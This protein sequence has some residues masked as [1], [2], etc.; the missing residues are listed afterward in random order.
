MGNKENAL[1]A[2]N[3]ILK[4]GSYEVLEKALGKF[5]PELFEIAPQYPNEIYY[6]YT[7]VDGVYIWLKNAY[8]DNICVLCNEMRAVLGHLSEYDDKDDDGKKNLEK[9][10]GH[11]RRLSIDSLKIL[12]NGLDEAFDKW[13]QKYARY[14]YSRRDNKYLPDYVRLY[15]NAH[16]AYLD[17]QEKE[18]LGSDR[19]NS[20][21]NKY[22]DVAN[23]YLLLYKH[24]NNIRRVKIEKLAKRFR[25]NTRLAILATIV[26]ATLSIVDAYVF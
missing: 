1:K 8:Q 7:Y 13:I 16:N 18:N 3:N 21:I 25:W 6:Y 2:K 26:F 9:A 11:F 17:A 23:K 14:D 22:Y 20:I 10:Y 5:N 4:Y 19:G 15:H 12:C 24:H